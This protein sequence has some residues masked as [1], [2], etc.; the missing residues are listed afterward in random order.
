MDE[1]FINLD[2]NDIE[3]EI[4]LPIEGYE[5]LYAVSNMGRVKSLGNDKLRKDK[6]LRQG[7]NNKTGY[8]YVVLSK[9]G[10]IKTCSVHRLVGNAFLDNPNN[11]PCFNHKNEIKTDNRAENL[12]PCTQK[13]NL[14]YKNT[15]QRKVASTDW[16][17]I[18]EKQRNNPSKSSK[19]YQYKKD[20]TLVVIW[21]ST[22]ECGR[23]GFHQ[24]AVSACCRGERK[25]YR[26]YIW[27][28][29]PIDSK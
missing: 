26:G 10:K 3:G 16:K 15:Q 11:Y 12:E 23:N 7:K 8:L 2:L 29:T 9:E 17:A 6:I 5:G 19:V 1:I 22:R 4:W 20:G 28:Y 13:Y 14:N 18:A 24:S 21:E 27:S 25:Q